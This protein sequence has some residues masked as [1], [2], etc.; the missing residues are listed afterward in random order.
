MTDWRGKKLTREILIALK[1][2]VPRKMVRVQLLLMEKSKTG[3]TPTYEPGANDAPRNMTPWKLIRFD[4][5]SY[6]PEQ[7]AWFTV[8]R[9]VFTGH[10]VLVGFTPDEHNNQSSAGGS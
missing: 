1:S 10:I 4:K 3:Q 7:R 5:V 2:Q 9:L 6:E 8:Y